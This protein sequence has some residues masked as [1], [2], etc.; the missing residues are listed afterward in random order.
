MKPPPAENFPNPEQHSF[1]WKLRIRA[2]EIQVANQLTPPSIAIW[3]KHQ[4]DRPAKLYI[5][6]KN[7]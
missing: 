1:Q 2:E 5:P 7:C 3:D 4:G 6:G